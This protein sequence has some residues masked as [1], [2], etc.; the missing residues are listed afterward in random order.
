MKKQ[1]YYQI[2]LKGKIKNNKNFTKRLR[3]KKS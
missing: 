3:K 2:G 1:I